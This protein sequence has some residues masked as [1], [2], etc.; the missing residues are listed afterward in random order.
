M[1]ICVFKCL[2]LQTDQI[3]ENWS[4]MRKNDIPSQIRLF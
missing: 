1:N 4:R 3:F 2:T